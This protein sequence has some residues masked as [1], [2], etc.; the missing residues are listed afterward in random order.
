MNLDVVA[1]IGRIA[2]SAIFINGGIEK[3]LAASAT[4]AGFGRL[5]LPIPVVAY[6]VTVLVELV[7]GVFLLIGFRARAT[8]LLLAIWCVATALVAHWHPGDRNQMIH[9]MKNICMA[10]GML[11][12]VAFGPG[13]FGVG[14]RTRFG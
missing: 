11:Q 6:V 7:G 8:A 1:L 12:V 4:I 5:G 3:L 10:G 13:R 9:F 14:R 2:L